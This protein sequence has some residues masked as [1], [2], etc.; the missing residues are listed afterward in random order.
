MHFPSDGLIFQRVPFL[1]LKGNK[2]TD[3]RRRRNAAYE[4][5]PKSAVA[6][7]C[8]KGPIGLVFAGVEVNS[9]SKLGNRGAQIFQEFGVVC[10]FCSE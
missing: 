6:I 9:I 2:P 4:H 7:S 5:K 8:E 3:D 10:V 1:I